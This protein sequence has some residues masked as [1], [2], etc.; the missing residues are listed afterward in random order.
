MSRTRLIKPGFFTNDL[1]AEVSPIGRLLFA[2]LWTISDRA[3]RLEDR[4][5]RIKAEVL[6]FD[7]A[8]VDRLL[9]EL[10]KRGFISRYE[11]AGQ[12]IIQ[13]V[14]FTRHQSPHPKE[15]T[16]KLPAMGEPVASRLQ[17]TAETVFSPE[18]S[19]PSPI[20]SPL[21]PSTEAAD[22]AE[23]ETPVPIPK[24]TTVT[25]EWLKEVREEHASKLPASG[26]KSFDGVVEFAMNSE[27][28]RRKP[29]KRGYVLGQVLGAIER[30]R[31]T[32]NGRNNRDEPQGTGI[33]SKFAAYR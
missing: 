10:E 2:G 32:S 26:T 23:C 30:Q 12:K 25:E 17:D 8:N 19:I 28:F 4:P 3:G 7:S 9:G 20:L 16:S 1:L 29:D 15:P 33:A 11:S 5:K 13:I 6:P 31:G 24:K 22:A 21:P 27:Y 14:A 18:Y